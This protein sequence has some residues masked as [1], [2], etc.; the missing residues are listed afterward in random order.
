MYGET[1]TEKR[2]WWRRRRRRTEM[3]NTE[4]RR[5]DTAVESSNQERINSPHWTLPTQN[6]TRFSQSMKS[7]SKTDQSAFNQNGGE[8]FCLEKSSRV[9]QQSN[10]L[11]YNQNCFVISDYMHAMTFDE[12]YFAQTSLLNTLSN[13]YGISSRCSK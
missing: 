8:I 11:W 6:Q 7:F 3:E 4:N 13:G 5:K 10:K 9:L 1:K 12:K 2:L